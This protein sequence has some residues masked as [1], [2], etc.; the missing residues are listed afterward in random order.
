MQTLT[1]GAYRATLAPTRDVGAFRA[2]LAKCN[3][4][5]KRAAIRSDG[6]R[7]AYPKFGP[8]MS[9]ADYVRA[10]ESA[11][12]CHQLKAWQWQT[13]N[14]APCT[15]YSGEDSH[16]TLPDGFATWEEFD[17]AQSTDMA[18]VVVAPAE[19]VKPAASAPASL[20][21]ALMTGAQFTTA[22]LR[23]NYPMH[24]GKP[25]PAHGLF[26]FAGSIPAGCYDVDTG[27]SHRYPTEDAAI[28]AA[29]AAGATHVQRCDCSFAVPTVRDATQDATP[30]PADQIEPEPAPTPRAVPPATQSAAPIPEDPGAAWRARFANWKAYAAAIDARAKAITD[31]RHARGWSIA[32]SVG[33]PRNG[34]A[35]HNA[36][37]DDDLSGWCKDN[38][39]RLAAAKLARRYVNDWRASAA[40]DR[41][42]ARA[43][44]ALNSGAP[45]QTANDRPQRAAAGPDPAEVSRLAS[46]ADRETLQRAADGMRRAADH[47]RSLPEGYGIPDGAAIAERRAA[48]YDA[49]AELAP[50]AP[51]GADS[52]PLGADSGAPAAPP[53]A[54]SGPNFTAEQFALYGRVRRIHDRIHATRASSATAYGRQW[55]ATLNRLR[56][57]MGSNPARLAFDRARND[58]AH[59]DEWRALR[60]I[61]SRASTLS[62]R[63]VAHYANFARDPE[64]LAAITRTCDSLAQRGELTAWDIGADVPGRPDLSIARGWSATIRKRAPLDVQSAAEIACAR[65]SARLVADAAQ[66]DADP[67]AVTW[68]SVRAEG[69][70]QRAHA[71]AALGARLATMRAAAGPPVRILLH[72]PR[73]R[74]PASF[75]P[76]YMLRA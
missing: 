71:I 18:T 32:A 33:I 6:A 2:Q 48:E 21:G 60:A 46:V 66:I 49:A 28:A 36:S 63:G 62:A 57:A 68:Q 67:G 16:Q 56:S 37:I 64:T 35:L 45:I 50:A 8:A 44:D 52:G 38:P 61:R 14:D 51:L 11:N 13:L 25:N 31:R 12:S 74:I 24:Q 53:G 20:L 41:M 69:M 19:P 15:L 3:G 59:V 7:R 4:K 17:A 75:A 42:T 9:T 43:W 58:G 76:G 30:E 70:R 72:D 10:F 34:C 1:I 40:A 39:G 65:E 22:V 73:A 26:F 47:A 55:V 29:F 5:T 54:D 27:R 23:I